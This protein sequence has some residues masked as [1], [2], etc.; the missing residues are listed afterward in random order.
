ML[1]IECIHNRV[2]LSRIELSLFG[3]VDIFM[4][5][6]GCAAHFQIKRFFALL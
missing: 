1:S 2:R 5:A 4:A 6:I 3:G